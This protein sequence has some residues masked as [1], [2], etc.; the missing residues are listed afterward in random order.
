MKE[1]VESLVDLATQYVNL[2]EQQIKVESEYAK[3]VQARM[4]LTAAEAVDQIL[5]DS[6]NACNSSAIEVL[7]KAKEEYAEVMKAAEEEKRRKA[8]EARRKAEEE[9]RK[10]KEA[11]ER[12]RAEEE[13]IR[14][15][16]EEDRKRYEEDIRKWK[17]ECDEV[18]AK[19]SARVQEMISAE[20]DALSAAAAQKRDTAVSAANAKIASETN[21]KQTAEATLASLGAFKF[22]EKKT[23]RWHIED[24]TRLIAEAQASISSAQTA[25]YSEINEI[26]K[27]ANGKGFQF[28]QAAERELPLPIRPSKPQSLIREED[29]IKKEQE[30]KKEKQRREEEK[31]R[32]ARYAGLTGMQRKNEELKDAIL[33]YLKEYGDEM[34]ISDMIENIPELEG[35]TNQHTSALVR[36]LVLSGKVEKTS[37]HRMTFFKI[38]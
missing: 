19:R 31:K 25:Y 23:Q 4:A 5:T 1:A 2:D 34:T 26:D 28:Q 37:H 24:A 14:R 38:S 15:E 29:R 12:K 3:T 36:A 10:R 22:S 6:E 27:K 35:E 8:E 11:E 21:R 20:K 18:E 13:R 7:N 17:A 32:N 9:A 16:L 30:L 33:K